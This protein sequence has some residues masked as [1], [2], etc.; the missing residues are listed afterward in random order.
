MNAK[1]NM[2]TAGLSIIAVV[3]GCSSVTASKS[4]AAPADVKRPIQHFTV[5]AEQG[6]F[7]GWPANNGAWNWGDEILVCFDFHTFKE[8]NRTVDPTEHHVD[9][10]KPFEVVMSR[11]LDGGKTWK[12]ERPKA[13][14][15]SQR[16]NQAIQCPG[17]IDFTHPD[18]A[19]RVRTDRFHISYDRGKT[20]AGPYLLGNFGEKLG[21]RTEY[22]INGK[23]NC[24]LFLG[25]AGRPVCIETTDG[26]KTFKKIGDNIAPNSIARSIMPSTVRLSSYE[27]VA[28]VRQIKGEPYVSWIDVYRSGDNGRTW[29]FLSK[30]ADADNRYWNGNPPSMATLPDGRIVVTYGYRA[31]PYGIRAKISSDNGRTWSNEYILR[32]DG[33]NWDL[34]Y[35]RTV[36]RKDGKVVTMYYFST[37]ENHN[38]RI[39]ATIWDPDNIT[40][41]S[42]EQNALDEMEKLIDE[43]EDSIKQIEKLSQGKVKS[44]NPIVWWVQNKEIKCNKLSKIVYDNF[45]SRRLEPADKSNTKAYK[46]YI[47]ELTRLCPNRS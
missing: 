44:V 42:A 36:V 24:M 37:P 23:D 39:E 8:P 3:V 29:G 16:D 41:R 25:T 13:F 9:W 20:W 38:H 30:V 34:G 45:M 43:I 4:Q 46:Q 5:Y 7:C 28:A 17:G 12:L 6:K 21:A 33:R 18:F 22:I 11:S 35:T 1:N 27:L 31:V 2:W 10:D 32:E 40:E 14:S 26:G 47:K 15:P 19:M